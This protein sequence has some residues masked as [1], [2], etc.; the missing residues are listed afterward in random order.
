MA[1]LRVMHAADL[2]DPGKLAKKIEELAERGP[3][4]AA[5]AAPTAAPATTTSL[6]WGQLVQRVDDSGQLRV[7]QM[8]RD[9]I[10]VV[11]LAPGR[12]AYALANGL[13][14]DPGP[15]LRDAL[16]KLTGDRWQV[17]RVSA[18]GAPTLRELAEAESAA[19]DASIREHPLVKS[20][21]EAFP[22]AELLDPKENVAQAGGRS[23]NR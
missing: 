17:E 5:D 2:P 21:L 18:D 6:D 23:W 9:W 1:L 15:E 8:M 16:L 7:A 3:A 13:T 19:A 10:R 22:D 12:L 20:A 4:P 14:D 11:E